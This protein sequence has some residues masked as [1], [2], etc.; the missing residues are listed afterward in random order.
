MG[1][2][3]RSRFVV[4]KSQKSFGQKKA[5]IEAA[6]WSGVGKGGWLVSCLVM[7][8]DLEGEKETYSLRR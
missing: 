5:L 1:R 7:R 2:T 8:G 3:A 4:R 6:I